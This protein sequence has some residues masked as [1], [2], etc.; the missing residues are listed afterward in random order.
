MGV[1]LLVKRD[2]L[3]H[4]E[5]PGNKWRKLKFNLAAAREQGAGTLL[6]FGGAYSN[7]I[8][9]TAAAGRYFGFETIGVVRGEEHLPLNSSL[10]YAARLG[11][12]LSYLDRVTYRR[13][14][15]PGIIGRLRQRF[16]DFYLL[17]EGREQR[18]R[19][20]RLRGGSDGD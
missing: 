13:K 16:G 5:I 8:R 7:H 17:P 4:P 15:E 1:R 11:M 9:A 2:D 14:H 19:G 3:I 20:T 6:T 12:R 18:A 10:A